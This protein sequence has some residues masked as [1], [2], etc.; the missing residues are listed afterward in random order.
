MLCVKNGVMDNVLEEEALQVY[1]EMR[2][3]LYLR[4]RQLIADALDATSAGESADSMLGD[5]DDGLTQGLMVK[6]QALSAMLAVVAALTLF[7]AATILS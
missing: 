5:A 3:T 7:T 2:L 4:A 1:E 6:V